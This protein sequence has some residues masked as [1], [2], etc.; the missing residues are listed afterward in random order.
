VPG[1]LVA[2]RGEV[3]SQ[4]AD[5]LDV[6]HQTAALESRIETAEQR[7]PGDPWALLWSGQRE[8]DRG[9]VARGLD[10]VRRAHEAD[11]ERVSALVV[12]QAMAFA[13]RRDFARG[14][15]SWREAAA[16]AGSAAGTAAVLRTAV[17]GF[18][19]AGDDRQSRQ[20]CARCRPHRSRCR[21]SPRRR[22]GRAWPRR[23]AP[24]RGT[25]R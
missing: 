21:R 3:V 16:L 1:N 23:P 9:D 17:D 6:F 5:S 20:G 14:S 8:L 15:A 18:L 2:Y 10:L 19:A 7:R 24:R 22:S 25:S 13:L 11:P 4:G 12:G